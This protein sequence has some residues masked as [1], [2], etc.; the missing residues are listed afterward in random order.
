MLLGTS[1]ASLLRNKWTGKG[2]LRAGYRNKKG[3][4]VLRAATMDKIFEKNSSATHE[5]TRTNYVYN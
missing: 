3:N 5:A 2:V 1:G 4:G